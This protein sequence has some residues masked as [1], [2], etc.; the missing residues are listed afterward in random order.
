MTEQEFNALRSAALDRQHT[1]GEAY[2]EFMTNK[3]N[4]EGHAAYLQRALALYPKLPPGAAQAALHCDRTLGK[5]IARRYV[6]NAMKRELDNQRRLM[7]TTLAAWQAKRADEAKHPGYEGVCKWS[8]KRR[9][10][11]MAF[12]ERYRD[13]MAEGQANME[14]DRQKAIMAYNAGILRQKITIQAAA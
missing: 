11:H 3:P 4:P 6:A 2:A 14:R 13:H 8:A 5:A 1:P 7:G 12:V 10:D 9:R